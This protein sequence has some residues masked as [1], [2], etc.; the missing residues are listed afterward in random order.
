MI[1]LISVFLIIICVALYTCSD[2]EDI[3]QQIEAHIVEEGSIPLRVVRCGLFGAPGV[4]KTSS[5]KRLTNEIENLK[6]M[7]SLSSTGIKPP[8]TVPLYGTTKQLP[9]LIA[10]QEWNPQDL[11]SQLQTI[12]QCIITTDDGSLLPGL[13]STADPPVDGQTTSLSA[14]SKPSASP[15]QPNPS[16][17]HSSQDMILKPEASCSPTTTDLK[18]PPSGKKFDPHYIRN[19]IKQKSWVK[20]RNILKEFEDVT[21]LN[22]VDTG[23]QPEYQDIVPVLLGA[24]GLS[25]LFFNLTQDPEKTYP[26]F[27]HHAEE[28]TQLRE[29]HSQL[30]TL[31]MLFQVLAT[32]T[33]TSSEQHA[34]ILVGTH[35]DQLMFRNELDSFER[36]VVIA[37]KETEFHKK[38]VI[39][40]FQAFGEKRI[41]FPLD[42]MTG[43]QAEIKQLQKII[44]EVTEHFQRKLLPTSWLLFHL[45]LRYQY[46]KKPGYCTMEQCKLLAARCGIHEKDVPII[47]SYFHKNFGTIL[48]FPDVSCLK[49]IVICNP[50]I[51]FTAINSL[52]AESFSNNPLN[53]QMSNNIRETGEIAR[54]ML[55]KIFVSDKAGGTLPAHHII[56]LLKY[57]HIITEIQSTDH[58]EG[59]VLFMPCLLHYCDEQE[60]LKKLHEL[61]PAP[62]F[63]HFSREYI[64]NG[65]FT[66]YIVGL[67]EEWMLEPKRY[68]NRISFVI[69]KALVARCT[70]TLHYNHIQVQVQVQA[71]PQESNKV[72]IR[73][74]QAL[75]SVIDAM[76][77]KFAYLEGIKPQL[78]LLCPASIDSKYFTTC[79]DTESPERMHCVACN[80]HDLLPKHKI[81]FSSFKVSIVCGDMIPWLKVE[82]CTCRSQCF[83]SSYMSKLH[84]L[85]GQQQYCLYSMHTA[86]KI[87]LH[88]CRCFLK[89]GIDM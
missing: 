80:S 72:C 17:T 32:L 35:R 84:M 15:T 29:F 36:K 79:L 76:R 33:N 41:V 63:I 7:P 54:S 81:W 66:G 24:S 11:N 60:A 77:K 52:V 1:S 59:M 56:E 42:N 20:M 87:M 18:L 30:S 58:S 86:I 83:D 74:R 16:T 89:Q 38:D 61:N 48:Y 10:D 47:L 27:Y 65:F 23:G 3:M 64:P 37:L 53:S 34:A 46:Q 9:V 5:I 39:K 51:I 26:V 78:R 57:H 75:M 73:I 68:K 70:L 13:V 2:E 43:S 50:S 31:Q 12:L 40:S 21:L 82:A 62:L 28:G 49:D 85:V 45:A 44:N 69:D 14:P 25:L 19:L 71:P 67:A 22:I 55:D 4:G 6:G 8:I 88:S